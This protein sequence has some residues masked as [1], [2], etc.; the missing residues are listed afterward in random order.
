MAATHALNL[1]LP[2]INRLDALT[3]AYPGASTHMTLIAVVRIGLG[4]A[5]REPGLLADELVAMHARRRGRRK[6]QTQKS[7]GKEDSDG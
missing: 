6:T 3:G 4:L 2:D 7:S 5:T 1:A